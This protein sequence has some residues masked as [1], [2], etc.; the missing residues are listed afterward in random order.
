MVGARRDSRAANF[1]RTRAYERRGGMASF[2]SAL[3]GDVNGPRGDL[4]FRRPALPAP[5]HPALDQKALRK[6]SFFG[7]RVIFFVTLD[8]LTSA[9]WGRIQSPSP[10]GPPSLLWSSIPSVPHP[11]CARDGAPGL[12]SA[13]W[14]RILSP[15]PTAQG[16]GH[17][18]DCGFR[19]EPTARV[20]DSP[21]HGGQ[22]VV[23]D[24]FCSA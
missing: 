20:E 3:G 24:G 12:T 6:S 5:K 9:R 17:P 10:D 16:M 19:T 2:P 1:A 11:G 21:R 8:G 7:R 22:A 18:P 14:G 13:R 4:V 15:I 23:N